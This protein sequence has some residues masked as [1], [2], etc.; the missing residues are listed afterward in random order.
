MWRTAVSTAVAAG[1]MAD[2]TSEL[3]EHRELS[4]RRNGALRV[5]ESRGAIRIS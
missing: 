3:I 4:E 1:C 2:I 5:I